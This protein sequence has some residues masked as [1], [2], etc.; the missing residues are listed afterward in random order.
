[1][2][3]NLIL[4]NKNILLDTEVSNQ[5][6]INEFIKRHKL[7]EDVPDKYRGIIY[8]GKKI[9]NNEP[10]INYIKDNKLYFWFQLRWFTL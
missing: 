3:L 5:E 10:I 8:N 9:D 1:M 2:Q 7:Y 4:H 6:T